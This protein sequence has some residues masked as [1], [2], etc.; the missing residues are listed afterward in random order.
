MKKIE[1]HNTLVRN[2]LIHNSRVH[3]A[4]PAFLAKD[5]GIQKRAP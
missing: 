3:L 4:A 1:D 5:L 2:P